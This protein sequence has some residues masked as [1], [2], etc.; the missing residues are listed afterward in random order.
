MKH[1]ADSTDRL[2]GIVGQRNPC[3]VNLCPGPSADGDC[4]QA[5]ADELPCA[6]K[7]VI[8]LRGTSANGLVFSVRSDQRGPGCP[9]AWVDD[10][11]V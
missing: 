4:P 5:V 11:S 3:L 10:S 8:P 1:I 9:L 6:G 2:F 7:R